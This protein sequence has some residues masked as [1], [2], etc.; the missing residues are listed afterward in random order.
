M[1]KLFVYP[2]NTLELNQAQRLKLRDI[3]RE[4]HKRPAG[5]PS[6]LWQSL[7]FGGPHQLD[8]WV[9]GSISDAVGYPVSEVLRE[10]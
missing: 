1:E 4:L 8:D 6:W 2:P 9:L 7:L 3:V 10:V 5:I